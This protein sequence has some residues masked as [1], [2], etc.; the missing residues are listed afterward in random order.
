L[1]DSHA[2]AFHAWGDGRNPAFVMWFLGR[3]WIF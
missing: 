2:R 3:L 1:S